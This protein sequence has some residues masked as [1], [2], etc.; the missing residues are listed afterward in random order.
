MASLEEI[1]QRIERRLE[2]LVA[3]SARL[4]AALD[5]LGRNGTR[6]SH[7]LHGGRMAKPIINTVG[8]S[9]PVNAGSGSAVALSEPH[10]VDGDDAIQDA[11]VDRAIRQLRQ[12]LAAG[13]RGG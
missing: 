1:S 10:A 5:E 9:G 11:P 2:E 12:E 8:R 6:A 3:E 13:L 4:R 7:R